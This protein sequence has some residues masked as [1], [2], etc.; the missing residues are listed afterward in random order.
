VVDSDESPSAR[1]G[2]HRGVDG[3]TILRS[4]A[5]HFGIVEAVMGESDVLAHALEVAERMSIWTD[6]H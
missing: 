3:S 2:D 6:R 5:L 4:D 1:H